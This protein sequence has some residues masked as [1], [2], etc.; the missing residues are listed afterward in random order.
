METL[1]FDANDYRSEI[2]TRELS[3]TIEFA[4]LRCLSATEIMSA[5]SEIGDEDD[6]SDYVTRLLD[7]M[8]NQSELDLLEL[9]MEALVRRLD[10]APSR[11]KKNIDRVL[12]RLVRTLPSDIACRFAE[13][14][15]DH[16]LKTT[17]ERA[18][19][20]LHNKQI[21]ESIAEK[22]IDVF[23]RQATRNRLN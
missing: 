19:S 6:Q 18:F 9:T 7:L 17:R 4:S 11:L 22:L 14:Y 12:L 10:N 15:V 20:A 21:S 3:R 1:P 13:P 5:L 23:R 16:R 8:L 2:A